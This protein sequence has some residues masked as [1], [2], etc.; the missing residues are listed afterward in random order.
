MTWIELAARPARVRFAHA[1][2]AQRV[3]AGDAAGGAAGGAANVEA[4]TPRPA[5][6]DPVRAF[7]AVVDAL[8]LLSVD[9]ATY[10]ALS[11]AALLQ[12]NQLNA[13]AQ[14]LLGGSSAAIAGEV[15]R[16]ST[17]ELGS[18]GLAQRAGYRTPE[19]FI[20]LTT[21]VTGREAT[22]A[23]RVGRVLLD[24]AAGGTST[25]ESS[26]IRE[27]QYPWL[28]SVA[29]AVA[30]RTI[31]IDAAGNPRRPGR[32]KFCC[33]SHATGKGRSSAERRGATARRR[34]RASSVA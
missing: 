18:S 22:T 26:E 19:Q 28:A 9:I 4:A 21:G 7:R 31:T 5:V 17:P 27:P 8:Q 25:D 1:V 34:F 12:I 2:A 10:S 24:A 29:A 13:T 15:A 33:D 20:K 6:V 3:G 32:A 14:R 23:V 30:A 16:R 11:E